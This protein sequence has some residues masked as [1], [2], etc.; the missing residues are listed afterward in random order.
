MRLP[1]PVKTL[2]S[3]L[4]DNPECRLGVM[5]RTRVAFAEKGVNSYRQDKELLVL[6]SDTSWWYGYVVRVNPDIL[7]H[8]DRG[9]WVAILIKSTLCV[10]G[11]TP[12]EVFS[13]VDH[14]WYLFGWYENYY[15]PERNPEEGLAQCQSFDDAAQTI[16]RIIERFDERLRMRSE[17]GGGLR[18]DMRCL[19][20]F[21]GLGHSDAEMRVMHDVTELPIVEG[22][23]NKAEK[24][25]PPLLREAHP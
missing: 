7:V 2:K 23:R 1:K 21:A 13:R 20:F 9:E 10:E 19:N 17:P 5:A 6:I 11:G 25:N 8:R 15:T 4:R 18:L 14:Y 3:A 16:C 12:Q 22:S 24:A